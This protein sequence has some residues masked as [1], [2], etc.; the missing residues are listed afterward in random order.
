MTSAAPRT[1]SVPRSERPSR[2]DSRSDALTY[3][4]TIGNTAFSIFCDVFGEQ[5]VGSRQR[6]GEL[7]RDPPVPLSRS[8]ECVDPVAQIAEQPF[9]LGVV[10]LQFP[11]IDGRPRRGLEDRPHHVVFDGVVMVDRV[12]QKAE[13][14]GDRPAAAGTTRL[15]R[16][17][18]RSR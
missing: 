5:L 17:G 18:A 7:G 6:L 9:E 8:G 15:A 12:A 3:R 16:T 14:V 2:R 10:V 13:I 4:A 1:P 11:D